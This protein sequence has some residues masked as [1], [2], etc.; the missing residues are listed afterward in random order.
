MAD[1]PGR[2]GVEDLAQ[3]EAARRGDANLCLVIIAAAA[4]RERAQ[5]F[6]FNAQGFSAPGIVPADDL[7]EER[8]PVLD[9]GEVARPAQLESLIEPILEVT[10]TAL[11]GSILMGD[12]AIVARRLHLV[13]GA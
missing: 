12:P 2:R 6:S 11:D 7:G 8:A 9:G 1:E 5:V 4:R 10:M 3:H 13:I